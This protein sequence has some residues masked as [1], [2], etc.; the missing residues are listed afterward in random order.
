MPFPAEPAIHDN[1]RPVGE[2]LPAELGRARRARHVEA[3]LALLKRKAASG[4]GAPLRVRVEPR[5]GPQGL[6]VPMLPERLGLRA[7]Q[8][9]VPRSLAGVAHGEAAGVAVDAGFH[10]GLDLVSIFA[11]FLVC[12]VGVLPCCQWPEDI[13]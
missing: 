3:A 6:R 2:A 9:R 10:F 1:A 8:A 4:T 5:L 13:G 7:G 12:G 11:K